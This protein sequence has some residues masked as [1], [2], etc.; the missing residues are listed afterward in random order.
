MVIKITDI[1]CP[2]STTYKNK[3]GKIPEYYINRQCLNLARI[4]EGITIGNPSGLLAC[5]PITV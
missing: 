3:L 4:P 2:I 5:K 1:I